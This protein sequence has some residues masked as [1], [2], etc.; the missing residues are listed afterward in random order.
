MFTCLV[1]RSLCIEATE[2]ILMRDA[3]VTMATLKQLRG[4]GVQLSI[5][6]FG[7]GYS[8]LSYLR[9]FPINQLKID[10]SFVNE[11]AVN[12]DDAAIIAAIA[13]LARSLSLEVVAE[14]VETAKQ[15]RMLAQQGCYIMQG[16]FFS[17]PVP[18]GELTQMIAEGAAFNRRILDSLGGPLATDGATS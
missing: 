11:L 13:S 2:S 4:L 1:C 10:R 8:S 15:A 3:D 9:R 14:G 18:A 5:D 7:T 16:Y 12:S 17:K 6:D